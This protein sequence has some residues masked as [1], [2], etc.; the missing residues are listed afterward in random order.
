MLKAMAED[1]ESG[2]ASDTSDRAS[3]TPKVVAAQLRRIASALEASSNPQRRLVARDIARLRARV[4]FN[5]SDLQY[6]ILNLV[7]D[8]PDAGWKRLINLARHQGADD[9]TFTALESRNLIEE[10]GNS[11]Y[12]L[13]EAGLD[14]IGLGPVRAY[15]SRKTATIKQAK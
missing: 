4:A 5:L 9:D 7:Y 10:D 6:D 13:T 12:R 1:I 14:A 15:A 2:R 3:S 11:G 8:N